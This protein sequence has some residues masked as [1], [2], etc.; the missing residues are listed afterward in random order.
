M[1]QIS[2]SIDQYQAILKTAF[3]NTAKKMDC[4]SIHALPLLLILLLI[5]ITAMASLAKGVTSL[6][7]MQ[8]L[9]IIPSLQM[10]S[11]AFM[12]QIFIFSHTTV[13]LAAE[14]DITA[15]VFRAAFFPMLNS[16]AALPVSRLFL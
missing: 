14:T 3:P 7:I 4:I 2:F 1:K 11:M 12:S 5:I 13:I 15:S 9:I 10:L 16:V 8:P 6:L